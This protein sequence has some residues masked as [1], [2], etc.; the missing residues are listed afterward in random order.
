MRSVTISRFRKA[1][2]ELPNHVKV[3]ARKAYKK[4]KENTNN[5]GLH[6]KLVHKKLPIYSIRIGIS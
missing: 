6:F 3:N 2:N 1:Y 4:W 5:T